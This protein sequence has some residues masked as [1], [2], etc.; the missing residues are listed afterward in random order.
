M[1]KAEEYAVRCKRAEIK[2]ILEEKDGRE[3]VKIELHSQVGQ[4]YHATK[5]R[6]TLC[7]STRSWG[8]S[9]KVP[10]STR[11]EVSTF[12]ARS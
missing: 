7:L 9:K 10:N 6:Y 12:V 3:T 11:M 1:E 2:D 5:S 8:M 4:R